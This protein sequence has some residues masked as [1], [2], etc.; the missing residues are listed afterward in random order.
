M[1][2]TG[3]VGDGLGNGS[4]G[5]QVDLPVSKRRGAIYWH[6]N[7]GFTW[8]PRAEAAGSADRANLLSPFLAGSTIYAPAPDGPPDAGAG[9]ALRPVI[10]RRRTCT[11]STLYTLSPGVRGGWNVGEAQLVVGAAMPI[12][13]QSGNSDVGVF[14]YAS[15]ELPFIKK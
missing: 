7:A 8:L 3:S 15:Y 11:S 4:Y 1:L 6:C 13:W 9:P 14:L 2:P 10:R 12:T 5:L